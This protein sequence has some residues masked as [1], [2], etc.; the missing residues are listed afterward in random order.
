[1]NELSCRMDLKRVLSEAEGIF[2]QLK[3]AGDAVPIS[4]KRIIGFAPDADSSDEE[5]FV[6]TKMSSPV[7]TVRRSDDVDSIIDDMER[8]TITPETGEIG[9]EAYERAIS[10]NYY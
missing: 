10:L 6:N 3:E 2:E 1:M 4:V 8:V 5:S 9:F 7:T